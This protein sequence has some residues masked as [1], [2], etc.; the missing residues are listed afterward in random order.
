MV[1]TTMQNV[2]WT[3]I[4]NIEQILA[5]ANTNTGSWFW[6]ATLYMVWVILFVSTLNFGF[7]IALL[8]ASFSCFML[9]V[10]LTYLGLVSWV[11]TAFFM[12]VIIVI[13][14]M[15]LINSKE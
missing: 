15:K 7:E 3:N 4:T 13:V 12:G 2:N 6:T 14:F 11:W 10:L 9:G 1:N 8:G 5:V